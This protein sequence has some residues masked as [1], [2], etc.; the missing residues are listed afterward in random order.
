[1]DDDPLVNDAVAALRERRRALLREL[2]TV[3]E[4]A[5]GTLR[6]LAAVE[7]TLARLGAPPPGAR[8]LRGDAPRRRHR[9]PPGAN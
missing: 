4:L 7:A 6:E 2:A 3:P 9:M 8:A 5:G 1:M